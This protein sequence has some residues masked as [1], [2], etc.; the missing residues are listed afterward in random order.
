MIDSATEEPSSFTD[1]YKA[2][3]LDRYYGRAAGDLAAGLERPPTVDPGGLADALDAQARARGDRPAQ[4]AAIQR[5]RDPRAR[6]IVTGQQAGLLLGPMYTLAK[7][8]TT[9][10]LAKRLDAAQRPV[11]PVFWVASQDHDTAEIDHAWLLD[12]GEELR[13]VALPMPADLPAGRMAW[14]AE[15]NE[16]LHERLAEIG[17][18]GWEDG[19]TRELLAW[20]S[21]GAESVG[22]VFARTL[23]QVLGDE[24]LVVLDP[25]RPEIARRFEPVIRREL[26]DPRTGPAAIGRAGEALRREGFRPQLG[27]S[28]DATNLFV[29]DG[30]G[31]R[32]LLRFDGRRFHPD[33][34]S[35]ERWTREDLEARLREDPA[36][37]TPAAGLR[38]IVQ[39]AALPTAAVVVG[40]G[41]LRYFAQ[42]REV[43]AQHDVPMPT[44]WPRAEATVL[45]PPVVRL[46]D[47]HDLSVRELMADPDDALRR[48]L[49]ALHGHAER[50]DS[51]RSRLDAD[52]RELLDAVEGIDPTLEGPVR[53]GR[54]V[55]E[56]TVTRL[57]SKT[58]DALARRDRITTHQFARLRAHLLPDGRPQERVLSPFS[59]FL[60]Y[61]VAPVMERLR[62]LEPEGAQVVTIDP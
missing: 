60:A 47:K 19:G 44:V 17:G 54:E 2:G 48:R 27:R 61:G 21:E 28:E 34:R 52:V 11:V 56:H 22:E 37:I 36:A 59:F 35:E 7:A 31:P 39:D 42:L 8:I 25:V 24:G 51:V 41:E 9:L 4:L 13:R 33:G 57:R 6:T 32:R 18:P 23:S 15:W 50:F 10:R 26:S 49:L 53:R 12:R 5:L 30:G 14:R 45:A 62:G 40:P 1:R 29:Q 43:Y 55:L 46:L 38:P 20:A 3:A 16:A 58:A